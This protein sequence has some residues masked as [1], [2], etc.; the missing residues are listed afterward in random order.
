MSK[1]DDFIAKANMIILQYGTAATA[2]VEGRERNMITLM[3]LLAEAVKE[4]LDEV[5]R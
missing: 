3:K 5:K 1:L 2:S 4:E